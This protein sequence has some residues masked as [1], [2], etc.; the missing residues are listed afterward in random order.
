MFPIR[1]KLKEALK[2]CTE[3][4]D[5]PGQ[6]RD[7]VSVHDLLKGA[8]VIKHLPLVRDELID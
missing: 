3:A 7:V 4:T 2:S 5:S 8:A 6:E 1:V